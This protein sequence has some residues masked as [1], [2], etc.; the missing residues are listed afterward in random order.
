M[1]HFPL[2][3]T[4]V[5]VGRRTLPNRVLMGSMHLGLEEL[6][7]GFPRMAA[8]YAERAR[9]GVGLIVTGG[10]SPNIEGRPFVNGAVLRSADDV[11]NHRLIT[12][13]VHAEGGLVLLQ[14]L[15]FGRYAHH[16]DLVAPSALVAPISHRMPRALSDDEVAQTVEDYAVAASLACSAGYDGIELMGSEG[17]LINEFLAP[18]TNHR[19]APWGGDGADR[20]RFAVAVATGVREAIGPDGILSFRLSVVDLVPDGSTLDE[21]RALARELEDAGVDL[22]V[23]GI[24]WHEA[25]VPT[26]ATSVPR[27]AFADFTRAIK[28]VVGIPVAASNRINTPATAEH[29]L[30]SGAADLVSLARP[31][32]ADPEFVEKAARGEQDDINTCIGCNQACIDHTF[33]GKITSCLVNPRACNETLLVLAPTRRARAVA[34]VGAGPAGLAAATSAARCGHRVTLYEARDDI[35][36]QF[37]LAR[38]IPGKEEFSETL[39]YFRAELARL[40]VTVRTGV[41]VSAKQLADGGFDDIILASGVAPRRPSIP[42]AELP[43]VV[44]YASVISGLAAVG[45]RVV[46]LGAGGIGFDTATFLTQDEPPA[47][48]DRDRFFTEWGVTTDPAVRGR[49]A[50]EHHAPSRRQ[51]TVLQRK[52][53]KPGAGLGVTTGWIHRAELRHRGVQFFTGVEYERIT[54]TGVWIRADSGRTHLEADNIV[55]CTGQESVAG[56]DDELR[57]LGIVPRLIGGA[58]LAGELDAKRAIREGT[59]VAVALDGRT[60]ARASA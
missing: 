50:P 40:A 34:V 28:E 26:I 19:D 33:V 35:G 45:P 49:L 5:R 1:T 4:P 6:D 13:A 10:I 27:G 37:D 51:V 31:L 2:L 57:A 38:R 22:I 44:D 43:L 21:T 58:R 18:A 12:E 3:L 25:R 23:T 15:H 36:G 46:I 30:A 54:E 60:P 42:G 56:L 7:D 11:E 48:L 59:E 39:R 17:Y 16:D 24:G 8:F 52:H 32:L 47:S 55:L 14:L 20:R 9:N 29:I 41:R 53:S